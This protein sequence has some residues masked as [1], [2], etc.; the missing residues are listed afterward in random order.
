MYSLREDE[1]RVAT[2]RDRC[3]IVHGKAFRGF[4]FEELVM[5][6]VT[7]ARYFVMIIDVEYPRSSGEIAKTYPTVETFKEP[8]CTVL[9]VPF[10]TK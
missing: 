5:S 8:H 6:V 1:Q 3:V 9:L 10:I 2:F 4:K 7:K